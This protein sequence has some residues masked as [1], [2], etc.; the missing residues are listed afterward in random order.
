MFK[1]TLQSERPV[2]E[3]I[4]IFGCI[5]SPTSIAVTRAYGAPVSWRATTAGGRQTILLS[6]FMGMLASI[7]LI[8]LERN[9]F[10]ACPERNI[11]IVFLQMYHIQA[12]RYRNRFVKIL[13][14]NRGTARVRRDPSKE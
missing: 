6:T 8:V 11:G 3:R 1:D 12:D 4:F 7:F 5:L 2:N 9:P 13:I 10:T 14:S